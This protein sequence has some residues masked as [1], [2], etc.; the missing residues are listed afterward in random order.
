MYPGGVGILITL[1]DSAWAV[2]LNVMPNCVRILTV[3]DLHQSEKLYGL[4][5]EAVLTHQPDLV[6]LVGDFLDATGDDAGKLPIPECARF[7][8]NLPCKE[9]LFIRGNHENELG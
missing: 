1:T 9:V 2:Q 3:A 4:L 7:L 5:G 8:S 6:V